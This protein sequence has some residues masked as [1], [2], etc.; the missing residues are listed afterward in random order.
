[1]KKLLV[2]A[3]LLGGG[4]LSFHSTS[5]GHG[6]QYRGPGDTVPPG[7]SGPGPGTPGPTGPTTPGPNTPAPGTPGPST[8]GPSTPGP[9]TPGGGGGGPR[10]V[11]MD[12]G[13]D[14]TLWSFWWEFNKDPF[15]R[16]K[17]RLSSLG[18]VTANSDDFFLGRANRGEAR[19]TL[20]PTPETRRRI[21]AALLEALRTEKSREVL[22]SSMIALAKIGENDSFVEAITPFLKDNN[23]TLV[24]T[25]AV[26]LG[27][28]ARPSALPVLKDLAGDTAQGRDL[29]ARREVPARVRAF[30][31]YGLGLLGYAT[32]EEKTG[33]EVAETLLGLLGEGRTSGKDLKVAAAISLGLVNDPDGDRSIE[34]LATYFDE[35]SNDALVR[36]HAP[37][38][39]AKILQRR[40]DSG[41]R[42]AQMVEKFAK[43]LKERRED[44]FVK[45][46]CVIA[47]GLLTRPSSPYHADVVR[48]LDEQI[49]EGRDEQTRNFATIAL[50]NAGG[51]DAAKILQHTL[52]RGK[53]ALKPWAGLGLGVLAY[54]ARGGEQVAIEFPKIVEQLKDALREEKTADPAAAYALAL[55]LTGDPSAREVIEEKL[56]RLSE[57]DSRGYACIALGLLQASDAKELLHQEVKNA[58]RKP[59]LLKQAAIGLGLLSD[60][61]AVPELLK[62]LEESKTLAVQAAVATAL[63]FIGD[64]RSVEPLVAMMK[65]ANLTDLARGFAAVAL[66]MMADKEEFPWNSKISVSVNYRAFTRTLV[67]AGGLSGILDIL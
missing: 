33:R 15:L 37:V 62:I 18:V 28:L 16:L 19:D 13:P 65:D 52:A 45:Q 47:L 31:T 58:V 2:L 21:A 10:T 20:K 24:E 12:L 56:K 26:A 51:P 64:Q 40:G 32:S 17:E 9:A 67:G 7:G 22:D 14:L 1:M 8:P 35:A 66:G 57:E 63:G 30:A 5:S 59:N 34:A 61:A 6:G 41:P 50:A 46:S 23:L 29:V 60:Q 49:R 36:A 54:R 43:A 44:D 11:G 42:A 53:N 38:S 3:G 55:G 48:V 25:A 39:I 4:L 27:I